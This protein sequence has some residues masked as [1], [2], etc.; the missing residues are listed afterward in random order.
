MLDHFAPRRSIPVRHPAQPGG[1]A[2]DH[3]GMSLHHTSLVLSLATLGLAAVMARV[4][5]AVFGDG[6]YGVWESV[7]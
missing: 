2:A 7:E 6:V 3:R 1:L 4:I 5:T